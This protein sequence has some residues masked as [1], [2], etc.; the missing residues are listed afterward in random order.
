[1]SN[2][3][4]KSL[5]AGNSPKLHSITLPTGENS[6]TVGVSWAERNSFIG[7][8]DSVREWRPGFVVSGIITLQGD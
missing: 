7:K 3:S 8:H 6:R 5:S 1:M 4:L 2:V